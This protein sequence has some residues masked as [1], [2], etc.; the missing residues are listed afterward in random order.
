MSTWRLRTEQVPAIIHFAGHGNER[1]L[2]I[3]EDQGVL[4]KEIPLDGKQLLEMLKTMKPLARL[5]VLNTCGSKVLAEM[6]VKEGA[7]ECAIGWSGRVTDSVAIAFSRALYGALGDGRN[8]A[9]AVSIAK[10]AA[11]QTGEPELFAAVES[12]EIVFI[13]HENKT[14]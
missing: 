10:V 7:V 2:S 5:C 8:I 11:G 12:G 4:A 14:I 3:V 6:L 1:S 9:E 13:A